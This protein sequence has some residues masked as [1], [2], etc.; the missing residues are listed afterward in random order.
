MSRFDGIGRKR[1]GDLNKPPRILRMGTSRLETP[2]VQSDGFGAWLIATA[3]GLRLAAP[4]VA[5]TLSQ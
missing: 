3:R 1:L 4:G 2:A 5:V